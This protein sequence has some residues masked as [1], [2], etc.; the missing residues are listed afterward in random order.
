VYL[1]SKLFL[2]PRPYSKVSFPDTLKILG[3]GQNKFLS[4]RQIQ[5]FMYLPGLFGQL[6]MCQQG[7]CDHYFTNNCIWDSPFIQFVPCVESREL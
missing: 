3:D 1:W 5:G 7:L 4:P 2:I 6:W